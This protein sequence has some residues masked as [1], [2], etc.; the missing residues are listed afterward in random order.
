MKTKLN[1]TMNWLILVAASLFEIGFATCM[2]KLRTTHGTSF[3]WWFTGFTICLVLSVYLLYKV[4]QSL[5]LGTA[6]AI[7]TGSGA[8][9]IVLVGIFMYKEPVDFWRLFFMFTLISSIVGLKLV[10]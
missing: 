2:G 1:Y 8:I 6:Y 7:W 4:T 10:S 9:G 5:P 3:Y